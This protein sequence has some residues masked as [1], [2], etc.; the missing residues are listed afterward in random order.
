MNCELLSTAKGHHPGNASSG[1]P[2]HH[3]CFPTLAGV[4]GLL[5]TLIQQGPCDWRRD[6]RVREFK[7]IIEIPAPFINDWSALP[8][9]SQST[10]GIFPLDKTWL[11][12]GHVTN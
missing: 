7:P 9:L 11:R 6:L 8:G 4:E 12:N 5:V 2:H 3:P 1:S 10:H